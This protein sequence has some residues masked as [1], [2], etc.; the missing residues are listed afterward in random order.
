MN[1]YRR[2]VLWIPCIVNYSEHNVIFSSNPEGK[3]V[4]Y[5]AKS[6]NAFR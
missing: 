4:P 3:E 6:E 1:A 2:A 5:V